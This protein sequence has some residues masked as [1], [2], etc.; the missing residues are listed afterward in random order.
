MQIFYRKKEREIAEKVKKHAD[1]VVDTVK[2]FADA[3]NSYLDG[4]KEKSK[5]FT[6]MAHDIEKQADAA[7]RAINKMMYEGAFMPSIREALF[8]A[9]DSIDDVANEAETSGDILTLIEPTIPEELKD[10]FKQMDQLTIQC[11]HKFRDGIYNLFDNINLVFDLMKEVEQLEGEVDK[12]VWKS[13]NKVFKEL[14]IQSFSQK[15]MLRELILRV[16]S[17]SNEMEDASD[18]I[19]IIALHLIS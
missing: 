17:I 8:I 3:L 2:A 7:Q 5:A 15:L 13:L 16:N 19:D 4:E 10:D 18:K 12:Y 6:K 14:D 1:L 9:V 11:A